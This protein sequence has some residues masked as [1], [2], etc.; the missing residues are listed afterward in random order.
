M[1]SPTPEATGHLP[2]VHEYGQRALGDHP[3]AGPSAAAA[4]QPSPVS[5]QTTEATPV[6]RH[7]EPVS[8]EQQ[9]GQA[10]QPESHRDAAVAADPQQQQPNHVH[11]EEKT[12]HLWAWKRRHMLLVLVAFIL[13]IIGLGFSA[14]AAASGSFDLSSEASIL[15]I[16]I[17]IYILTI[18]F[19]IAETAVRASLKFKKGLHPS[20]HVGVWLIC[21]LIYAGLVAAF[22]I[23]VNWVLSD[24]AYLDDEDGERSFYHGQFVA[25]FVFICLLFLVT[26]I[27]FIIAC[28]DTQAY[29]VAKAT[30]PAADATGKFDPNH[31]ED[32][33]WRVT[34]LVFNVLV[35]LFG[36]IGF[37]I[38]LSM[39]RFHDAYSLSG[40]VFPA[41]ACAMLIAVV[42]AIADLCFSLTGPRRSLLQGINPGAHV[43]MWLV[44][45]I[46][47]AI[48]GGILT[49]YA[50]LNVAQCRDWRDR[51]E[52]RS[53]VAVDAY[54]L[55]LDVP[56]V[57]AAIV[58]NH[59]RQVNGVT[60]LTVLATPTMNSPSGLPTLRP[61]TT[62]IRGSLPTT[63]SSPFGS[64]PY[65]PYDPY[66]DDPDE[67][68]PYYTYPY[69]TSSSYS[70]TYTRSSSSYGSRPTDSLND[71]YD[72]DP[73]S[74]RPHTSSYYDDPYDEDD[75]LDGFCSRTGATGPMVAT[76]VF[77]WIVFVFAFVLFVAACADTYL[78]NHLRNPWA[79]VYV[80]VPA[81][82]QQQQQ[83]QYPQQPIYSNGP[84]MQQ[85]AGQPMIQHQGQT[86]QQQQQQPVQP[87][88]GNVVEY[89]G[90]AQ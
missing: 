52:R 1:A 66:G 90:T 69:R 14:H 49:T 76:C 29:N 41:C 34:K 65:D 50:V 88:Q 22:A 25:Q 33:S 64:D 85:G 89:Y 10:V 68:D 58:P 40:V 67:E 46:I 24:Y 15:A 70:F 12:S 32:R 73:Y 86:V 56:V 63:T 62:S 19:A 16:P 8:P 35:I 28:I 84:M 53:T 4:S 55:G 31:H 30:M 13:S 18:V 23:V 47:L 54:A 48:V 26:F 83:Y 79:V 43:G 3:A 57:N 20:V 59:V 7:A 71:P 82:G 80:P 21:W 9:P 72:D 60:S 61:T 78:R 37:A 44:T 6:A 42:W 77:M 87:A 81:M 45:W 38:G 5:P 27:L 74:N 39:V 11:A 2:T 51:N 36:I 75:D 17:P